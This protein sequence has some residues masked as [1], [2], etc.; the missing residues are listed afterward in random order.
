MAIGETHGCLVRRGGE[1]WCWGEHARGPLFGEDTADSNE[2]S[3]RLDGSFSVTHVAVAN[4]ITCVARRTGEILC[5][6][7]FL[8]SSGPTARRAPF[9][10]PASADAVRELI[11]SDHGACARRASGAVECWRTSA[12]TDASMI[13]WE[14]PRPVVLPARAERIAAFRTHTC[15]LL[16]GATVACWDQAELEGPVPGSPPYPGP[17]ATSVVD[18]AIGDAHACAITSPGEVYCWGYN[19][20]DQVTAYTEPY[21]TN[22]GPGEHAYW[23]EATGVTLPQKVFWPPSGLVK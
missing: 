16:A 7:D 3:L 12:A 21:L 20:Y 18:L 10:L 8:S 15:A 1:L 5:R 2:P 23:V 17:F 6:A 4:G 19:G 11:A 13:E 9:A 22:M 14:G